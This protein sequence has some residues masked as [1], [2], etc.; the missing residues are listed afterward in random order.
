MTAIS[1][2]TIDFNLKILKF[3]KDQIISDVKKLHSIIKIILAPETGRKEITN[4]QQ[5]ILK[6]EFTDL[7]TN[8][9]EIFKMIT[10]HYNLKIN[11]LLQMIESAY[12]IGRKEESVEKIQQNIGEILHKEFTDKK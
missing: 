6:S 2:K 10:E 3:D 8:F 1:N 5:D 4:E 7:S 9:P 12:K 11:I